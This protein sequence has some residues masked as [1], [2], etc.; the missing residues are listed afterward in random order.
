MNLL[1]VAAA[2]GAT[3]AVFQW[4][5]FKGLIG[6]QAT[7]PIVAFV[8]MMMF[9]VLFGLSMDY[10][11]FLL[12]RVREEY[13]KTGDTRLGVV[14]G[15]AR[16][17][18]VITSAALIMISV[19][20]T[21]LLTNDIEIKM[22]AVGLTVAVLVDAT[23]VRMVLVPATMALMGDANWWLPGWLD[24]L[25]PHVDVEGS[26]VLTPAPAFAQLDGQFVDEVE[27]LELVG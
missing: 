19:F 10:Q 3:V 20:A 9:A 13:D 14:R 11:V 6:L 5:W 23:V 1:S 24:R 25:L 17:A 7:V 26:H 16:T 15:L 22:F 8:P 2:Y 21:F 12:T 27:Q 18:R 4:G